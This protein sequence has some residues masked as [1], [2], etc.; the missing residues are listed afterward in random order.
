MVKF[1]PTTIARYL[2]AKLAGNAKKIEYIMKKVEMSPGVQM[3][4]VDKV[5]HG[6]KLVPGCNILAYCEGN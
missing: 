6:K 1:E 3:S 4:P 5:V 2:Q